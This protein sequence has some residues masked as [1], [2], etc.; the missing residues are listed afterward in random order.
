MNILSRP[1][2]RIDNQTLYDNFLNAN[3]HTHESLANETEYVYSSSKGY[4]KLVNDIY[5][6]NDFNKLD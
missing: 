1:N 3:I 4:K 6:H 5:N 2:A